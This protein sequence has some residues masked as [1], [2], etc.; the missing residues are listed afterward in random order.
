MLCIR[1]TKSLSSLF[2]VGTIDGVG[3]YTLK[4]KTFFITIAIIIANNIG[5][6]QSFK[7]FFII[8]FPLILYPLNIYSFLLR[9]LNTM[10]PHIY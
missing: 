5:I 10:I 9:Y 4:N 7:I 6:I 1:V 8:T 3:T 2:I